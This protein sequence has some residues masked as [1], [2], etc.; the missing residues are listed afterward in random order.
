MPCNCDISLETD[1]DDHAAL[2]WRVHLR[3]ES[4]LVDCVTHPGARVVD[5]VENA[6]RPLLKAEEGLRLI[7]ILAGS[8]MI[9]QYRVVTEAWDCDSDKEAPHIRAR[10]GVILEDCLDDGC[11]MDVVQSPAPALDEIFADLVV[12]NPRLCPSRLRAAFDAYRVSGNMLLPSMC[13][14]GLPLSFASMP[15]VILDLFDND[16]TELPANANNMIVT[17]ALILTSNR[18]SHLPSDLHMPFCTGSLYISDNP[19]D[20]LPPHAF[21]ELRGSLHASQTHITD[22]GS[23]ELSPKFRGMVSLSYNRITHI[24]SHLLRL[25]LL[26]YVDLSHNKIHKL[27]PIEWGG[28]VLNLLDLSHNP[29]ESVPAEINSASIQNLRLD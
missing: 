6:I 5:L 21:S 13:I 10:S 16:I 22:V 17:D 28:V 23:L 14:D 2:N 1:D 15:F 24:P 3:L 7:T 29:I 26:R 8:D 9:D 25:P 4:G 11:Y 19:I 12:G 27:P 18:I 20:A